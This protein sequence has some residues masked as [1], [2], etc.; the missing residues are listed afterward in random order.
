G[1][2]TVD[3]PL[4]HR[5]MLGVARMDLAKK[6]VDFWTIGPAQEVRRLALAPDHKRAYA[7]LDETG[8]WELWTF[9]LVGRQLVK[10][11]PFAG[12][13]RE[14]KV[15]SSGKLLYIFG[16]GNTIDVFDAAPHRLLRTLTFDHEVSQLFV[17]PKAR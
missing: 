17:F 15:S 8:N 13:P 12:R 5:K 16:A 6:A 1:M 2:F 4:Q 9:D 14:V 10:R 7:L 3:D 11:T